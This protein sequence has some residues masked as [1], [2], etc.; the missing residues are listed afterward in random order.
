MTDAHRSRAGGRAG[1][2]AHRVAGWILF[3]FLVIALIALTVIGAVL[4]FAVAGWLLARD[5]LRS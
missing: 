1:S 5:A 4:C 3:P 2:L